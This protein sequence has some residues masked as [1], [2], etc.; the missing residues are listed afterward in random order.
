[1]N[2]LYLVQ[3]DWNTFTAAACQFVTSSLQDKQQ[4]VYGKSYK[5]NILCLTLRQIQGLFLHIDFAF[6]YC[7][8]IRNI[9]FHEHSK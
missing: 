5:H 2:Y 3:I 4:V 1:M 7:T 8:F 9:L 6:F